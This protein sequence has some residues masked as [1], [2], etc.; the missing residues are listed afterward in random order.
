MKLWGTVTFIPYAIYVYFDDTDYKKRE[1]TEAL[2]EKKRKEKSALHE[3]KVKAARRLRKQQLQAFELQTADDA[4][5]SSRN[6]K[7]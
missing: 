1:S 4:D 3:E 6:E 5:D 7:Q 2:K